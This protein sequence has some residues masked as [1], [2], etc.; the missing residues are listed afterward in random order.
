[1]PTISSRL[2]LYLGSS[3]ILEPSTIDL[4]PSPTGS[5]FDSRCCRFLS[6]DWCSATPNAYSVECQS[7]FFMRRGFSGW[8][9]LQCGRGNLSIDQWPTLCQR[10][11]YRNMRCGRRHRS[12]LVSWFLKPS[13]NM[14]GST[15]D[16]Y[17]DYVTIRIP[18]PATRIKPGGD[19]LQYDLESFPG[20]SIFIDIH[21]YII[22]NCTSIIQEGATAQ[23]QNQ[24]NLDSQQGTRPCSTQARPHLD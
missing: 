20:S 7:A 17:T 10:W 12:S 14:A 2:Y 15:T 9:R 4:L 13:K 23:G 8:Q 5:S 18:I 3:K 21:H 6:G 1:M 19:G 11:H 24:R 16:L 22:E